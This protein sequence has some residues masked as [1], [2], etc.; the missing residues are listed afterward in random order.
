MSKSS[1]SLL[2]EKKKLVLLSSCIPNAKYLNDS[3]EKGQYFGHCPIQGAKLR[4]IK[5]QD[6]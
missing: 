6:R 4:E 5:Y 3:R 2:G 1:T